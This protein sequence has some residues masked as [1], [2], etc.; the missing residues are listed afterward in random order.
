MKG[1]VEESLVELSASVPCFGAECSMDA[2][3]VVKV[4]AGSKVAYYS[5]E[6]PLC[7]SLFVYRCAV[8]VEAHRFDQLTGP[9]RADGARAVAGIAC[10]RGCSDEESWSKSKTCAEYAESHS[11]QLSWRC[12]G[13]DEKRKCERTL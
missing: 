11:N 8:A 1:L 2:A 3:H 12:D 9:F 5:Y 6:P 7:V 13:A 4:T 10:C